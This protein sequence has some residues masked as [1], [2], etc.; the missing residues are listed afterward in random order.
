[1]SDTT[2]AD[3]DAVIRKRERRKGKKERRKLRKAAETEENKG[4]NVAEQRDEQI[5]EDGKVSDDSTDYSTLCTKHLEVMARLHNQMEE[6]DNRH[7]ENENL[8]AEVRAEF[9][10]G[11][12]RI[13]KMLAESMGRNETPNSGNRQQPVR[14]EPNTADDDHLADMVRL[15]ELREP[16]PT[17]QTRRLTDSEEQSPIDD[18]R[19]ADM[20]RQTEQQPLA[21]GRSNE[22]K[23]QTN[24]QANGNERGGA[25]RRLKE[26]ITTE[27]MAKEY[28]KGRKKR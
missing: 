2:E 14:E 13:D 24:R 27:Q 3:I 19:V 6:S 25:S 9:R 7:R 4:E 10:A 12:E 20:V 28:F 18:D 21:N 16:Y 1:M 15:A 5:S 17:R 26:P 23:L 22:P 11:R 8:L